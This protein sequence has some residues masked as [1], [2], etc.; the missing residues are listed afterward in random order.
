[1]NHIIQTRYGQV[2]VHS[3]GRYRWSAIVAEPGL[4]REFTATTHADLHR[5]I[6]EW[7]D[8]ELLVITFVARVQ[9]WLGRLIVGGIC[10]VVAVQTFLFFKP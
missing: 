7:L 9:W 6:R 8:D 1:M 5:Q 4:Y 10:L 2:R 3:N